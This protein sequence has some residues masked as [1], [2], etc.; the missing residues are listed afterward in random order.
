MAVT[1]IAS[2]QIRDGAITDAK[3]AAGAAIAT[4][5]LAAGGS[6]LNRD[7]SVTM[8]GALNMGSQLITNLQT[9][10]AGTDAVNKNYADTLFDSFPQLFKYK[11]N[12]RSST[13]ANVT[14]ANPGPAVFDGVTLT[15]GD[16]LAVL[17]NT[18]PA[19]NGLYTF[20]GSG[21]ALTR[22]TA[23]NAWGEVVG[24]L[25]SVDQGSTNA[26]RVYLVTSDAGGT[27]DTTAISFTNINATSGLSNTNFIDKEIPSGAINSVNT[28]Y[29]LANIPI[30]GSEHVYLNGVLQESGGGNDYTI[31]SATI[32]Y[33]TAPL[34]DD[35]IRVSY[36]R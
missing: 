29:I 1:D 30:A 28:T 23:M 22:I 15:N 13:V 34:T 26:D 12:A 7:G 2:R 8:T 4:N 21:V 14:I 31:S 6:F 35:K 25:F 17:V 19:E 9:P 32:T 27:L 16:I 18:A 36:R 10:S 11:G 24:A 33:L 20:N 5:K 3:V